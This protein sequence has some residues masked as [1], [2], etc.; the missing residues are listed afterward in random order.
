MPTAEDPAVK[1]CSAY[2]LLGVLLPWLIV[3]SL[4]FVG[5]SPAWYFPG[6][7]DEEMEI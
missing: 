1:V 7:W 6:K 2:A 5:L 4:A 3:C